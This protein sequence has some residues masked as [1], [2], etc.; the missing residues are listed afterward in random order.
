MLAL[1]L[2]PS[3]VKSFMGH[4][5]RDEIFD[6]F[7]L[8]SIEISAGPYTK[9]DGTKVAD[10]VDDSQPAAVNGFYTW[11]GIKPIAYH[12]IKSGAKPKLLKVVFSYK[13]TAAIHENAG[14]LFLNVLYEHDAVFITSATS[15]KQFAMDKSLDH[16]WDDWVH[17]FFKQNGIMVTERE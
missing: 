12:I 5:L 7:E 15:Q 17:A 14:A 11:A 2:D 1:Q 8:R 4:L 13:N 9:I 16:A 6:L 10:V 3:Q